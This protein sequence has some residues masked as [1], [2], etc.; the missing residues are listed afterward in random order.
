MKRQGYSRFV[1]TTS[2][3]DLVRAPV[4]PDVI[5]A[6]WPELAGEVA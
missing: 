5:E 6:P 2:A 1:F 3:V 4:T